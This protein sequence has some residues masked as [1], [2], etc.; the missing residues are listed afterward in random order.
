MG[1]VY[2]LHAVDAYPSPGK[3]LIGTFSVVTLPIL[4]IAAYTLS[5]MREHVDVLFIVSSPVTNP[6]SYAC[7][8][9]VKFAVTNPS[10]NVDLLCLNYHYFWFFRTTIFTSMKIMSR[11]IKH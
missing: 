3:S 11:R 6:F 5:H 8:R 2:G 1:N 10:L 7:Y 4:S 9:L